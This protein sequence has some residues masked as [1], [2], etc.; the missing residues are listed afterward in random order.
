MPFARNVSIEHDRKRIASLTNDRWRSITLLAVALAVLFSAVI[1]PTANARTLD[2]DSYRQIIESSLTSLQHDPSTASQTAAD[3]QSISQ[4]KLPDGSTIAPNLTAIVS[5]LE[6]QPPRT[7]DA[8]TGLSSIL[9]QLD[10][11]QSNKNSAQTGTDASRSLQSIL[12]RSEFHQEAD[13]PAPSITGWILSELRLLLGPIIAPVARFLAA[14]LGGFLPSPAV[15]TMA[16]VVIGLV[17][18]VT[19]IVGPIRGIRRGFGPGVRRISAESG[20]ARKTAIE[21]RNEADSL[22]RA[23]SYRLAIRTLYLAAL[24]RLDEQGLLR[25]ERALTNREVLKAVT[26]SDGSALAERLAPLVD[27]FDRYWYGADHCTEQD[28]REF[29]QLSSWTWEVT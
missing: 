12:A 10:R 2:L 7:A 28:Y 17:A 21:L 1:L 23:S 20:L 4:V 14:I 3:L 22:A 26:T 18:I 19:V 16:L 8:I 6:A 15:W 27:R 29:A 9:T 24:F 11:A 25:F 5:D 13:N